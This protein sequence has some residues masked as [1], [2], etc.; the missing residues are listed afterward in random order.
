MTINKKRLGAAIIAGGMGCT[1]LWLYAEQL[2]DEHSYLIADQLEVVKVLSSLEA[3]TPITKDRITTEKVPRKFLPRNPLLESELNI[4]LGIP[5]AR[6]VEEGAMLLTDDFSMGEISPQGT[7]LVSPLVI[8]TAQFKLEAK[9]P[10][11][12]GR[13]ALDAVA[14]SGGYIVSSDILVT[15]FDE[16]FTMVARV[17]ATKFEKVIS[18]MEEIGTPVE[19]R[20]RGAGVSADV[21]HLEQKIGNTE[22][23]VEGLAAAPRPRKSTTLRTIEV[24]S[25]DR[26]YE[27]RTETSKATADTDR[28]LVKAQ[29]EL[30]QLHAELGELTEQTALSTI[31][32]EI[33]RPAP[34]VE[35][36]VEPGVGTLLAD[37]FQAS[38]RSLIRGS[39]AALRAFFAA[40]PL[41]I[42]TS[43]LMLALAFWIRRRRRA[44]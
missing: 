19:R 37:E 32:L 14:E 26:R 2:D 7:A 23:L 12:S 27:E 15:R 24:I 3:G 20:L 17:P 40:L 10:A 35:P 9:A 36:E 16:R 25:G 28:E 42:L 41:L 4:Y 1:F 21:Q 34:V 22:F 13:T 11:S 6:R 38:S 8:K 43:P 29:H 31:E 5:L 18:Q 30:T 33:V 44:A 39:F